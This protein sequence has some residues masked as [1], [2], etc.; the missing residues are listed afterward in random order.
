M[1]NCSSHSALLVTTL[2]VPHRPTINNY[3]GDVSTRQS[4]LARRH[5]NRL[6]AILCS[7]PARTSRRNEKLESSG[8]DRQTDVGKE[9][10]P[11]CSCVTFT[12]WR[13]LL[14]LL[15]D[16]S[17]QLPHVQSVMIRLESD[18]FHK[19]LTTH[20]TRARV[21]ET[22]SSYLGALGFKISARRPGIL[23]EVREFPQSLQANALVGP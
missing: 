15:A 5:D 17:I 12:T 22:P 16:G 4:G 9:L 11:A 2:S 14:A 6:L 18:Y 21:V 3:E 7:S 20:R 13:Q 19:C 23:T 10:R 1:M 8:K